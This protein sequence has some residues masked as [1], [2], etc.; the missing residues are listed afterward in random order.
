MVIMSRSLKKQQL[1]E[2][3]QVAVKQSKQTTFD[4]LPKLV[5]NIT[6]EEKLDKK[7]QIVITQIGTVTKEDE[8]E[9]K[10]SFAL[11]PSRLAFSTVRADLFFDSQKLCSSLIRILQ[12]PIATD[13]SEFTSVLNMKG[14]PAGS[15]LIK[16]EMY[17]LWSDGEKLSSTSKETAIDYV[18]LKRED[19]LIK[20]PIV[21]GVVGADLVVVSDSE[22]DIYRELEEDEKREL[23]SKRDEW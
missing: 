18:P 3:M 10:V 12:G 8:L 9:L 6:V 7:R 5:K 22:K 17:E 20:I 21:K 19:R 11:F 23:A 13:D 4:S 16:V 2:R 15:H 14:I 1:R